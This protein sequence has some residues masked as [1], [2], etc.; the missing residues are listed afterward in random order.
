MPEEPWRLLSCRSF[1]CRFTPQ[2]V[3]PVP[4]FEGIGAQDLE[5]MLMAKGAD[6]S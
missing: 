4:H 3:G 6:D 5:N 1:A 2:A